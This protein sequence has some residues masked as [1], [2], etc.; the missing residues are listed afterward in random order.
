MGTM[1]GTTHRR[2]DPNAILNTCRDV[3][4]GIN[5]I[6]SNVEKLKNL[7][8]AVE[9]LT[10]SDKEKAHMEEFSFVTEGITTL[11]RNLVQRM[12]KIKADPASGEPRNEKKVGATER[13]LK[14]SYYQYLQA[15]A[16]F[17]KRIRERKIRD[18]LTIRPDASEAEVM[19]AV[20][21]SSGTNM[22][23]QAV[24]ITPP[25]I[26]DTPTKF[27]PAP[28]RQSSWPGGLCFGGGEGSQ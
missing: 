7:I 4:G 25:F 27:R 21:D 17:R 6:E 22:F 2:D 10:S 18:F 1:N 16:D 3:D 9:N 13:R 19:E 24:S 8:L 11:Y 14:N 26:V 28:A 5:E 23:Q 15:D 20:E 12:S